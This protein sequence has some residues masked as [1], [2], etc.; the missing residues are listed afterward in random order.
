MSYK[1]HLDNRRYGSYHN[2]TLLGKLVRAFLWIAQLYNL[3]SIAF[4]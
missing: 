2:N 3:K 1:Q 4:R